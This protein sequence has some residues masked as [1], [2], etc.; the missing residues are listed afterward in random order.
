MFVPSVI[1]KVVG[2]RYDLETVQEIE[3]IRERYYAISAE[4]R[5]VH[6]AVIAIR[7][8]AREALFA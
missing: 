8:A 7:T 3:A 2:R 6:P 4:R 5:L 1:A